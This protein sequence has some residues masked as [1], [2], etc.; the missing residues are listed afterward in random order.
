MA[1]LTPYP[2]VDTVIEP[3][4]AGIKEILGQ[5]LVG[6]YIFGSLAAGG[7]DRE[8]DVDLLVATRVDLSDPQ[9]EQ[10]KSLH[11]R[12]AGID[13]WCAAQLEVTYVP[14][15]ALRRYNPGDDV[16]ATLER[17]QGQLLERMRHDTDGMVHRHT[18]RE[19]GITL[20]GPLPQE[21]IDPVTPEDLRAAM[22]PVLDGWLAHLHEAPEQVGSRGH[23]AY[24]VLTVCRVL[25]TLATGAVTSKPEAAQWAKTALDPRWAPLIDRA[26]LG[27]QHPDD[28][29]ALD[30]PDL[31][32]TFAFIQYALQVGPGRRSA[33][34]G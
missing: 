25:Y 28:P 19:K 20:F 18:L 6:V 32:A 2:E 16:H 29:V 15:S 10:L 4:L 21:L 31:Q 1:A 14:L 34:L 27:R 12:I 3:L 17:G 7:F 9:F 30:D 22:R 11:Q 23:H 8:S 26:W 24:I 33:L 5:D 13:S